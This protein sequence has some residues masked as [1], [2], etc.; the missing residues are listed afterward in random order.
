MRQRVR[1]GGS[2]GQE[3]AKLGLEHHYQL[4]HDQPMLRSR[5]STVAAA[6]PP[7]ALRRCPAATNRP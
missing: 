7:G 3:Q 1:E 4:P 5:P 2:Q 6:A